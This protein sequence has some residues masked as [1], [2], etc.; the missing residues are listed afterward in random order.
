MTDRYQRQGEFKGPLRVPRT[1][2][3]LGI[4]VAAI[5]LS[6]CGHRDQ[7]ATEQGMTNAQQQAADQAL[8]NNIKT[9]NA[10]L[11]AHYGPNAKR[12][13]KHASA[14]GNSGTGETAAASGKN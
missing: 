4:A 2:V 7:Q 3:F 8:T 11:E 13:N 14:A 6:A 12:P 1:F 10:W 9:G 5:S